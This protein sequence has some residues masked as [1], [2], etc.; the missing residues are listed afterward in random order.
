MQIEQLKK[1]IDFLE[2][3]EG[4]IPKEKGNLRWKMV[5]N[6]PFTKKELYIK[7]ALYL[8]HSNVRSLPEGFKVWG[9]LNLAKSHIESL[10]E[11]LKVGGSLRLGYTNIASLPKGLKVGGD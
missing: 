5:F 10:P 4:K 1:I 9:D 2:K 7:D 3:K 6:E 8:N 11:G